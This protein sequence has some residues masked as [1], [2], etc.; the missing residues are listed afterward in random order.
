MTVHIH[1]SKAL[2]EKWFTSLLLSCHLPRIHS[3]A[4]STWKPTSGNM[5]K[6]ETDSSLKSQQSLT[7]S[8]RWLQNEEK[9]NLGPWPK[10]IRVHRRRGSSFRIMHWSG[11]SWV[12]HFKKNIERPQLEQR[13]EQ[14]GRSP[15][16]IS[17]KKGWATLEIFILRRRRIGP[18][19]RW[20]QFY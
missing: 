2:V 6:K 20:L 9:E 4:T 16:S 12:P 18:C 1:F 5:P 8:F 15:R 11:S 7:Q 14:D 13:T 10:S 17:R 19:Q 3:V